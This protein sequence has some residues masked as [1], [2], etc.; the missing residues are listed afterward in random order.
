MRPIQSFQQVVCISHQQ[1]VDQQPVFLT[2]YLNMLV[3][4]KISANEV[5]QRSGRGMILVRTT[6]DHQS[7]NFRLAPHLGVRKSHCVHSGRIRQLPVDKGS[8]LVSRSA[9]AGRVVLATGQ[10]NSLEVPTAWA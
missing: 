9:S 1:V 4:F 6:F 8:K 2:L 7:T 5:K 10:R 3:K